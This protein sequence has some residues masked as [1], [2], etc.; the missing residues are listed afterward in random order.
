MD[1]KE[2]DTVLY[3]LATTTDTFNKI[4]GFDLD[5]TLIKTKSK[6]VFPKDKDDWV[7]WNDNVKSILYQYYNNCYKID[8]FT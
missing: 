5:G 6:K 2:K 8:L 7:L 3:S 4:A 1:F